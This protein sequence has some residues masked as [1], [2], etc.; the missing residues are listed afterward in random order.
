MSASAALASL[1]GD[2]SFTVSYAIASE[3]RISAV[4]SGL[5]DYEVIGIVLITS[6]VLTAI[7]TIAQR[8]LNVL[9]LTVDHLHLR[10]SKFSRPMS[11][12]CIPVFYVIQVITRAFST[13]TQHGDV[14][15][16]KPP[17]DIANTDGH[18]KRVAIYGPNIVGFIAVL[19]NTSQRISVAMLAQLVASTAIA[20]QPVRFDRVLSLL[21]VAVFFI[22][23]QSSVTPGP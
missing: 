16:T 8:G 20:N 21:S 17:V 1:G 5:S 10:A 2:V 3:L 22:F 19:L 9:R 4:A 23:L 7:P 14:T 11:I 6:I 15:S 13:P 18:I 12:C